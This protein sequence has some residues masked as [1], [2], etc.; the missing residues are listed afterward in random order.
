M[1]CAPLLISRCITTRLAMDIWITTVLL[2]LIGVLIWVNVLALLCI[3]LDPE[4]TS[5]Q[6]WGQSAITLLIPYV[7]ASLVLYFVNQHSPEV[8][9]KFYIPW[10]LS[11]I[12]RDEDVAK[13]NKNRR[14]M[15]EVRGIHSGTFRPNRGAGDIGSGGD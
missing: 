4:L 3:H 13:P 12:V 7:G 1:P 11:K 15:E 6:R 9:S 14:D 5:T 10:P 2:V 8:V